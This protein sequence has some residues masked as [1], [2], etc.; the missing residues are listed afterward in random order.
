M[1]KFLVFLMI[2]ILTFL[3]I[4]C[5]DKKQEDNKSSNNTVISNDSNLSSEESLGITSYKEPL[6]KEKAG[7]DVV[8]ADSLSN[9]KYNGIMLMEDGSSQL[10]L[11]FEDGK[12]ATLLVKKVADYIDE[13]DYSNLK[14]G[15]YEVKYKTDLD[16]FSRYLWT[17]DNTF[18]VFTTANTNNFSNDD[19]LKI[20]EG[21]SLNVGENY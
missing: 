18:Y 4:G 17:K 14:I 16:N 1:K 19:I 5:E 12:Q 7:Y 20:I 9:V 8:K 10:D 2:G 15:D 6:F 3:L 21:F 13:Q 11:E